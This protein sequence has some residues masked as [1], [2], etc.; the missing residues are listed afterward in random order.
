MLEEMPETGSFL[1]PNIK[2][3]IDNEF[4]IPKEVDRRVKTYAKLT[5][6]CSVENCDRRASLTD[7]DLCAKHEQEILIAADRWDMDKLAKKYSNEVEKAAQAE[8]QHEGLQGLPI[9]DQCGMSMAE[10]TAQKY[11][12]AVDREIDNAKE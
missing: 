6:R 9:C 2:R 11:E 1:G 8:C 5:S 10:Y 12:D 4:T 7:N 3:L